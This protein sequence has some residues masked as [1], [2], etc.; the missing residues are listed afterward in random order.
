MD[1]DVVLHGVRERR[2]G[3][4]RRAAAG[5]A[6]ELAVRTWCALRESSVAEA[7]R[8]RALR[9]DETTGAVVDAGGRP[10]PGLF[11]AVHAADEAFDFD[12][13]MAWEKKANWLAVRELARPSGTWCRSAV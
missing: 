11:S 7:S 10:V 2:G 12:P 5:P 6:P 13:M 3:A 1:G 9:V 8:Q 4:P